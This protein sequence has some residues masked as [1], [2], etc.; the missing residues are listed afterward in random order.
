[1]LTLSSRA[2]IVLEKAYSDF[3]GIIREL[4][5]IKRREVGINLPLLWES[6]CRSLSSDYIICMPTKGSEE[7][8]EENFKLEFRSNGPGILPA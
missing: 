4:G 7:L 1:M 6:Y 5:E 2:I 3:Q 8:N